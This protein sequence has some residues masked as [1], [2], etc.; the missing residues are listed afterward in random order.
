MVIHTYEDSKRT[1]TSSF[2]LTHKHSHFIVLLID[3]QINHNCHVML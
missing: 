3:S 2:E 1:H